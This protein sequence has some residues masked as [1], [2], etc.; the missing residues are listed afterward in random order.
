MTRKS[1]IS[2]PVTAALD[3]TLRLSPT[4]PDAVRALSKLSR[5]SLLSLTLNWLA[6][7][8]L[9][10]CRPFL[11]QDLDEYDSLES[12]YDLADTVDEVRE[13]YTELRGRKGGKRE[14]LD[15]IL[16]GD[17]RKGITLYQLAM[18]EIQH[19]LDHPTSLKWNALLLSKVK[20]SDATSKSNQSQADDS[21]HHLPRFNAQAFLLNLQ[22]EVSP[23]AKAHYHIM[24]VSSMSITI[25]RIYLHES[26]YATQRSLQS[27]TANVSSSA[28]A[29]S[30][31]S[32]FFVFPDGSPYVHVSLGPTAAATA[33]SIS[34]E[35][36]S[37]RKLVLDALPKALS[38]PTARYELKT[39]ALSARSL[40]S[41]LHLRG[42]GRTNAAQGGWSIFAED[43]FGPGALEYAVLPRKRKSTD[44]PPDADPADH[45][46]DDKENANP[47]APGKAR[48][49]GGLAPVAPAPLSPRTKRRR[50]V[51]EGRFGSSAREGD[52]RGIERFEVRIDDPF[53][54]TPAAAAPSPD[55]APAAVVEV[56]AGKKRGRKARTSLLESVSAGG[57]GSSGTGKAAAAQWAPD[58]RITIHGPHVFAGIRQLVEAGVVD[59]ER[60]PGWMTGEA[61]VSV[62]VVREGR[63][64]TREGLV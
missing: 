40:T 41:L 10:L 48:R 7:K 56:A 49:G 26:P 50:L 24:R 14:V 2:V 17:W 60:M 55:A 11:E 30:S 51:A 31:R 20:M 15:R 25:L 46:A 8:H 54:A 28:S 32:L 27:R 58:V 42:A 12:P 52:G 36:R 29:E 19:L 39:T 62:G 45:A 9:P 35:G 18:A 63:M 21:A 59:G 5:P 34:Q 13:A 47:A 22:K 4:D 16:E 6:P 61:G 44:P 43:S 1:K 33:T 37:L 23:L 53:P 64:L 57:T 3:H 38:R